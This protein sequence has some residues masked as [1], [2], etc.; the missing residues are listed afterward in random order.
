MAVR[1]SQGEPLMFIIRMGRLGVVED[2]FA[3]LRVGG[4][5]VGR[6]EKRIG[7]VFQDAFFGWREYRRPIE[8]SVRSVSTIENR[9]TGRE[10]QDASVTGIRLLSGKYDLSR[11]QR[12]FLSGHILPHTMHSLEPFELQ[13]TFHIQESH[14]SISLPEQAEINSMAPARN[15]TP[16]RTFDT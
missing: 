12:I 4:F 6:E 2:I 3:M 10:V 11:R 14:S 1:L 8:P 13:C 15:A 7:E 16:L 5:V 9:F